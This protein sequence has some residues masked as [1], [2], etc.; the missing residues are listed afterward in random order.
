MVQKTDRTGLPAHG[1]DCHQVDLPMS[2][3]R[4]MIK[5]AGRPPLRLNKADI[6]ALF[7]MSQPSAAQR[8]GVSVS[9]LK[10][11][12]RKLGIRQWPYQRNNKKSG[13]GESGGSD[14]DHGTRCLDS[15]CT[16]PCDLAAH[17]RKIIRGL[18]EVASAASSDT[19]MP[20]R[21]MPLSRNI[22]CFNTVR[23][24]DIPTFQD[25]NTSHDTETQ[26]GTEKLPHDTQFNLM[27]VGT[28]PATQATSTNRHQSLQTDFLVQMST[29]HFIIG[30][31]IDNFVE[32]ASSDCLTQLAAEATA[33]LSEQE[34]VDQ[35]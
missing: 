27:K 15:Q 19:D 18:P 31:F 23:P 11:E 7:H 1:R 17:V 21:A 4:T 3:S 2:R 8:L 33:C 5:R 30:D 12:C 25:E 20:Y 28:S 35:W 13:G 29:Q 6:T 9:W 24:C 14:A 10:R 26:G 32:Q 22:M 16:Q 34:F